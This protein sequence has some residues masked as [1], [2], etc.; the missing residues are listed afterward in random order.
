MTPFDRAWRGAKSDFR[1]YALSV[2]S[3]AVAF[4]CLA[5]AVLV[6][7][8]VHGVRE[9]WADTGR[10]SVFLKSTAEPEAMDT[11]EQALRK[12]QGVLA[13]RRLSSE[14]ARKELAGAS[15]DPVFD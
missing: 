3:V 15:S 14:Q 9:R 5:T 6:V 12:T 10:A 8:N 1:L 7:V 13:V 11:L 4:V 2:F